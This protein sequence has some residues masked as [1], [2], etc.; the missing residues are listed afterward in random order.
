M[1]NS[2]KA[3][4]RIYR[5]KRSFY[6]NV[7]RMIMERDD[8]WENDLR[9]RNPLRRAS[10]FLSKMHMLQKSIKDSYSRYSLFLRKNVESDAPFWWWESRS[11]SA[12]LWIPQWAGTACG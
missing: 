7:G 12:V 11:R 5:L 6:T 10:E 9:K 4:N 8:D 2:G 1:A 3:Q